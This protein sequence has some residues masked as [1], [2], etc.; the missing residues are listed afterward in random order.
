VVV[1]TSRV[2]VVVGVAKKFWAT[3]WGEPLSS[4]LRYTYIGVRILRGRG[5]VVRSRSSSTASGV[6]G[7]YKWGDERVYKVEAQRRGL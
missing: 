2:V 5:R 7:R 6:V 3:R 1:E 4:A